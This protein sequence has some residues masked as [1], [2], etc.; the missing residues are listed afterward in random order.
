[1]S[2]GSE[3]MRLYLVVGI[4]VLLAAIL[5]LPPALLAQDARPSIVMETSDRTPAVGDAVTFSWTVTGADSVSVRRDGVQVSTDHQGEWK[6]TIDAK[7]VI[8]WE[9]TATNR[10]G[11]STGNLDIEV[12]TFGDGEDFITSGPEGEWV[13]QMI[14]SVVPGI[15]IILASIFVTKNISPGPFIAAGIIAPVMAFALR[16]FMGLGSYWLATTES[17]LLVLAI[18]AWVQLE[19]S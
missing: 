2:I 10:S 18:V 8:T 12:V 16:A 6:E 9:V 5:T 1:M 3:I 17:V 15:V 4:L 14:V 19:K 7:G 13:L 11:T